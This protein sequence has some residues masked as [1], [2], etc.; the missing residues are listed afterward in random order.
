MKLQ[1]KETQKDY[2]IQEILQIRRE[3][4]LWQISSITLAVYRVTFKNIIVKST[5]KTSYDSLS[6]LKIIEM[7]ESHVK[8]PLYIFLFDLKEMSKFCKSGKLWRFINNKYFK[9]MYNTSHYSII[10]GS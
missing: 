7:K 10:A 9:A 8:E 4:K 2:G 1:E 3:L 6:N 5:N